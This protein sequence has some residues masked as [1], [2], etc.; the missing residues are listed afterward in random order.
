MKKVG[1]TGGSGFI[2]SYI[3]KKFLNEGNKVK[4]GVT[5][6][7][8][9]NKYEHLFNLG[10]EDNLS[11]KALDVQDLEV[12]RDF[13]KDCDI[14]IHC[15]TPFKIEVKDPKRDLY[16]PTLKG[17]EN[18]LKVVQDTQNI[19]KLVFVAS[20]AAYNTSFPF[21]VPSR[22]LDHLYTEKDTPYLDDVS[23]PYAQA[24]YHAHQLVT[25]F[26]SENP[27]P[28]FEVVSLAP[29]TVV[30]NSLS[31]RE[32][33]TSI[34]L[35]HVFKS[36]TTTDPFLEMLFKEDIEFALV[37]VEDV[38]EG[39]YKAA[40]QQGNHGKS[41]LLSSESWKVSD[42]SRMLNMQSP[43]GKGREV[44]SNQLAKK[45]LGVQFKP[46]REPLRRFSKN[47]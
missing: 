31:S 17:T 9:S 32:D 15:G 43:L 2:G 35:Q 26:V 1:I 19:K 40:T 12:L 21:P 34:G 10:N 30:G 25:A 23:I 11:I 20:V 42:I 22:S 29:V 44:Y 41:Y 38:A 47:S 7:S 37:D 27:D 39:V 45:E 8:Q 28:G 6:I 16:E 46:A 13:S 36:S 18:F 14:L 3:T 5:N 24:K 4:V 33:S